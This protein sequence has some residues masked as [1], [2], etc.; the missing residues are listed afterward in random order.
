MQRVKKL[1][2]EWT[3][4]LWLQAGTQSQ[5]TLWASQSPLSWVFEYEP[6][7]KQPGKGWVKFSEVI[8]YAQQSL[9]YNFDQQFR[10]LE[11]SRQSGFTTAFAVEVAWKF[12]HKPLAQIVIISKNEKDAIRFKDKFLEAYDSLVEAGVD[13]PKLTKRTQSH[14]KSEDGREIYVLTSSKGAGRGFTPTDIY[15]DELAWQVYARDIYDSLLPGT[16]T[17]DGTITIFS[18]PNGRG[19]L[20]E[21]I[22]TNAEDMDYAHFQFEWWFF[23]PANPYYKEMLEAYLKGDRYERFVTMA[24]K[25]EWYLKKMKRYRGRMGAFLQEYECSFGAGGKMV[26]SQQ[27]LN[28]CFVKNYLPECDDSEFAEV[29]YRAEYEAGH[30]Y[31]QVTDLGR[32]S[33]PTIIGVFDITDARA[34]L[35]E[36]KVIE[37]VMIG[38]GDILTEMQNTWFYWGKPESYHDGTGNGD[39]VTSMIESGDWEIESE[40]I[41]LTGDVTGKGMKYQVIETCKACADAGGMVLPRIKRLYEEFKNYRWDDKKLKQDSVIMVALG[42]KVF[43]NEVSEFTGTADLNYVGG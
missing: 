12:Q 42:T 37:G 41:I 19:N 17:T 14:I 40:A 7:I 4:K 43:F 25:A 27:S 34:K 11:K 28:K 5:R 24:R 10:I 33:D 1:K 8:T 13:M 16:E 6:K 29:F 21:E 32:K 2:L 39:A 9:L 38:W 18:T 20:Y 15:L 35:V 22:A 31:L 30:E 26:F 23:P 3:R 36:F